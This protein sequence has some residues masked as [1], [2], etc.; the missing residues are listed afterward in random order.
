MPMSTKVEQVDKKE[1]IKSVV[2]VNMSAIVLMSWFML[3]GL[4]SSYYCVG[5]TSQMIDLCLASSDPMDNDE[6]IPWHEFTTKSDE[7]SK[8]VVHEQEITF[9]SYKVS[10]ALDNSFLNKLRNDILDHV[11]KNEQVKRYH[12]IAIIE[13]LGIITKSIEWDCKVISNSFEFFK[14]I[15]PHGV[16]L[17]TSFIV[18]PLFLI[19]YFILNIFYTIFAWFHSIYGVFVRCGVAD[20]ADTVL[21][22]NTGNVDNKAL[23]VIQSFF[24]ILF[25]AIILPAFCFFTIVPIL[26]YFF[27]T[28]L[29][30][31]L[32]ALYI[33][34]KISGEL[35]SKNGK[36]KK[37][38]FTLGT[39]MISNIYTYMNYY[40]VV[41]S[42]IYALVASLLQDAYYF[43]GCLV[44]IALIWFATSFYKQEPFVGGS[45]S[46][47]SSA[48]DE[49][50]SEIDGLGADVE[51]VVERVAV[52]NP[53]AVP[54][55][56]PV[57]E[58]DADDLV[59]V[60]PVVEPVVKPVVEQDADELVVVKPVVEPVVEPVAGELK[61]SEETV[62][63]KKPEDEL[64]LKQETQQEEDLKK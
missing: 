60:K 48:S 31:P 23:S 39:S 38:P 27:I 25:Y 28:L 19:M 47:D 14:G 21:H 52:V 59:V 6:K 58:Q 4:L 37:T 8:P 18:L 55:V 64:I 16:V 45:S 12:H 53:D 43:V 10:K 13:L 1:Y 57:V 3:S 46:S 24:F 5:S 7:K 11:Q 29:I 49:R 40:S 34:F 54:V 63:N 22:Q 2:K 36:G 17:M 26:F 62:V 15:A 61:V 51:Q 56:E 30:I 42:I 41:F 44:A 33:P 32:Y 50:D 20:Y 35:G 9:N